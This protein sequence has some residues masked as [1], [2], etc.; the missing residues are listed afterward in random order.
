[1]ENIFD[2]FEV[3]EETP[4]IQFDP[5]PTPANFSRELPLPLAPSA[6]VLQL[7]VIDYDLLRSTLELVRQQAALAQLQVEILQRTH[8]N[9]SK[10]YNKAHDEV[11]D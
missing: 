7:G 9:I 10:V 5:G 11:T 4:K 8:V 6:E 1:M 3:E 2:T